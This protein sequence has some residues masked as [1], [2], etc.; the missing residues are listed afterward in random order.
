MKDQ[1]THL[2]V[3]P[4]TIIANFDYKDFCVKTEQQVAWLDT[5]EKLLAIVKDAKS[6]RH[7]SN[8]AQREG[9]SKIHATEAQ[10]LAVTLSW[11][12][13]KPSIDMPIGVSNVAGFLIIQ[14]VQKSLTIRS[15]LFSERRKDFTMLNTFR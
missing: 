6:R 1:P 2:L 7:L 10:Q 13:P 15:R 3:E 12:L 14:D 11:L 8:L 4:N 9:W 5:G